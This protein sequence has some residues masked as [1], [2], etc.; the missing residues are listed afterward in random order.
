M[1]SSLN[2]IGKK[3][4][5]KYDDAAKKSIEFNRAIGI[6]AAINFTDI[7]ALTH[8]KKADFSSFYQESKK[9]D[10]LIKRQ[11][12]NSIAS[13]QSFKDSVNNLSSQ[14][15]G[16]GDKEGLLA[17]YSGTYMRTSLSSVSN[18]VD[19]EIYNIIGGNKPDAE[20]LYAGPIS[21]KRIRPFCRS[22]VGKVFKRKDA[23]KFANENGSGL[24]PFTV[25]P[26]GWNCRH[27]LILATDSLDL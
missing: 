23:V 4:I 21:D 19:S 9:L 27:K 20:Y 2:D 25:A 8:I 5:K 24:N 7:S 18:L 26:G 10:S 12:V 22:H 3:H 17:R 16:A 6:K 11:L 1:A 15:L 14:L 13:G